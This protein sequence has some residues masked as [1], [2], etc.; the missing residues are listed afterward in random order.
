MPVMG[1]AYAEA[2]GKP[3][4]VTPAHVSLGLAVDVERKDGT[5][6]LVVPVLGRERAQLRRLRGPLR[7]ARGGARDN[8]LQPDAYQGANITLTNPGGIGTVAACRA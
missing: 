6:S 8:T 5:R 1:H 4:R 3:Q 7:R 2:D